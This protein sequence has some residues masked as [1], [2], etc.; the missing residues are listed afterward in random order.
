MRGL[1]LTADLHACHAAPGLL[2]DPGR[3]AEYCEQLVRAAGLTI[4]ARR[5]HA[6]PPVEGPEGPQ[7]GGVT[8]AILLAESHLAL[9]T[10]P[11][12]REVT[13]DVYVC[14]HSADNS[15]R[16]G[17]LMVELIALFAPEH[18]E[19]HQVR[20]GE[21]RMTSQVPEVPEVQQG[22]APAGLRERLLGEGL[23][24]E[25]DGPDLLHGLKVGGPVESV[26]SAHQHIEVFE[27]PRFGPLFCLDGAFMSSV[28]DEFFYH[29]PLVHCAAVSHPDPRRALIIGGGDGGS[30]EELLKHPGVAEIVLVELDAEVI[31]M[32]RRRLG[33]MHRGALDDPRVRIEIGDGAAWLE[34]DVRRAGSNARSDTG[35]ERFDLVI[36][37]LTE[38]DSPARALYTEAFFARIRDCL[39]P[40]GALSLHLGSPLVRADQV[41]RVWAALAAVFPVVRPMHLSVPLYG[42]PWCLAVASQSLDPLTLTP[43]VVAQR[44][45]KRALGELRYYNEATH[46]ALFALPGYVRACQ[47][48]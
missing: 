12:R 32:A 23:L 38:P 15:P 8:G 14:H 34:A 24:I 5:F 29:E 47:P 39:N 26:R 40:G 41:R 25:W 9:H 20:R 13:L 4:V 42:G 22:A 28:G 18:V 2:T 48:A 11:E 21:R 46:G 33:A 31:A 45:G 30:A 44:L 6:F 10:W 3:L 36:L 43:A 35:A 27:S 7:A 37:D 16:A 17:Q 19:R 1:H